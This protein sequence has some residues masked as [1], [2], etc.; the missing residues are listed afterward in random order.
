V[1]ALFEL[2]AV[3]ALVGLLVFGA[4]ALAVTPANVLVVLALFARL[5]PRVSSLQ[6][7]LHNL[8]SMVPAV[9]DLHELVTEAETRTEKRILSARSMAGVA[10]RAL[11]V[12][13]VFVNFDARKV[14]NGVD[15]DILIPGRVGIVGS[16]GAGKSTL[17][18][19]LLGL[20]PLDRGSIKLG[21]SDF[22]N[23]DLAA[24]RGALGYVPQETILFNATV[25]DNIMM[26]RPEASDE[27]LNAVVRQA[28]CRDFIMALPQGYDTPIGD[29][30]VL[31]SGGQRQRLGI[32]RALLSNPLVLLMDE[33]TSSLDPESELEILATLKE[34]SRSIGVAIVAHRLA[35]VRN[36]DRIYFLEEGRVIEC[37]EW[38]AL[39]ERGA[40][41]RD[42]ARA[43]HIV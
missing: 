1:R 37:G 18:H 34:L 9:I 10:P 19:A 31:L 3:V 22:S 40:R 30:G 4:Q 21:P 11:E 24:W 5:V 15:L 2:G 27:E 16:S 23:T 32:A 33:P 39:I 8:N 17:I 6:S 12:S 13:N 43:Q 38:N 25:R 28:H 20:V 14:L 36:A 7:Y 26:G 41:F 29:R 42:F 35:T